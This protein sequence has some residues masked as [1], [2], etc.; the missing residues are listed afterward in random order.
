MLEIS[1]LDAT[2]EGILCLK[3]VHKLEHS[4]VLPCVCY[5]PPE[6][7]SRTLAENWFKLPMKGIDCTKVLTQ[8]FLAKSFKKLSIEKKNPKNTQNRFFLNVCCVLVFYVFFV[9]VV[10]CVGFERAILSCSS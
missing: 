10:L 1:I 9:V 2:V 6:N 5:L 7:S 8:H 3:L 4:V